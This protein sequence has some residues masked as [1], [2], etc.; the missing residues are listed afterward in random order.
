M[1]EDDLVVW[2]RAETA[3]E[4]GSGNILMIVDR[5]ENMVLEINKPGGDPFIPQPGLFSLWRTRRLQREAHLPISSCIGLFWV[6]LPVFFQ[7][8]SDLL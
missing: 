5:Y 7:I 4:E 2:I 8:I 1:A 6:M 3:Q